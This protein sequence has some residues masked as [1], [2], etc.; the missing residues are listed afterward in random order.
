LLASLKAPSVKLNL[1]IIFYPYEF[2]VVLK[3]QVKLDDVYVTEAYPS[4]AVLADDEYVFIKVEVTDV[5]SIT[6]R[7]FKF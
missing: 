1:N 4:V 6:N 2:N 5:V 3:G 7:F